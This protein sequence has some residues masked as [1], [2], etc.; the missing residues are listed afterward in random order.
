MSKEKTAKKIAA[1]GFV[2]GRQNYV[3]L[4]IGMAVLVLGMI[5][6]M[7]GGSEDA[8]KFSPKIFDFQRLTLA[9]LV[10]LAGFGIVMY[11]ILKRSKPAEE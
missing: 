3:L 7:G 6:M 8:S 9:P 4:I 10:I 2:F 11:G 5:L 1:T